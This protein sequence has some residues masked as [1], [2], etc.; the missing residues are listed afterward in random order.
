MPL[1]LADLYARGGDLIVTRVEPR[2]GTQK[3]E[4]RLFVLKGSSQGI[5][6]FAPGSTQSW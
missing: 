4:R 2:E 3:A 5:S 1:E 6:P